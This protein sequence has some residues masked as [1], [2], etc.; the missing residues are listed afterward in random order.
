MPLRG[1]LAAMERRS[2]VAEKVL[3]LKKTAWRVSKDRE[4]LPQPLFW[5]LFG[6]QLRDI[7]RRKE[8]ERQLRKLLLGIEIP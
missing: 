2:E 3:S 8:K 5:S 4:R 7:K 1:T 6:L